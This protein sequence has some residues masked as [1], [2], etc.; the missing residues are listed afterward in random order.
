MSMQHNP[1]S[2]IP[3]ATVDEAF[4]ASALVLACLAKGYSL[5][6]H[7]GD[8]LVVRRSTDRELILSSLAST[9]EDTLRIYGADGEALG[10]ILLI[11]GNG[12]DL[13]ADWT[14][15]EAINALCLPLIDYEV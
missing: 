8:S 10:G 1:V 14:D 13:M 7:D 5:S 9:E 2:L 12:L 6:V 4:I 11:W 3:N 15:S